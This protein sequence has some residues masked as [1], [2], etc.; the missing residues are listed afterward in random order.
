MMMMMMMMIII[1]III[2]IIKNNSN[3]NTFSSSF[4]F[5]SPVSNFQGMVNNSVSHLKNHD[6]RGCLSRLLFLLNSNKNY[7]ENLNTEIK[8][9][10]LIVKLNVI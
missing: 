5:S 7:T 3:N 8:C 6:L 1:I 4:L 10:A 9:S 2:I